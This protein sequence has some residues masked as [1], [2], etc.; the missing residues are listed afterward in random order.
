[1]AFDK[2]PEC[3]GSG[4]VPCPLEY[5][6]DKHPENCPVCRGDSSVRVTCPDC[7]GSGEMVD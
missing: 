2:C 7:E 1:M 3:G 6:D 5:D 4:V